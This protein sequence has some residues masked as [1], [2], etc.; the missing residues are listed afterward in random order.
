M[1][2]VFEG[3]PSSLQGSELCAADAKS[4]SQRH[5]R[6]RLSAQG[7]T[8]AQSAE[9]SSS[10]YFRKTKIPLTVLYQIQTQCPTFCSKPCFFFLHLFFS[11]MKDK[12]IAMGS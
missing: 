2:T 9:H 8:R 10:L 12:L 11:K 1:Q 3:F 6:E 4:N 5:C 7:R